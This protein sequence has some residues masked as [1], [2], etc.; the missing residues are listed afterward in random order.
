M[1]PKHVLFLFYLFRFFF[2][3]KLMQCNLCSYSRKGIQ[4]NLLAERPIKA[5]STHSV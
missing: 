4:P 3:E 1:K 5:S 2:L